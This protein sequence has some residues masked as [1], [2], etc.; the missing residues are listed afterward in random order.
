MVTTGVNMYAFMWEILHTRLVFCLLPFMLG[1]ACSSNAPAANEGGTTIGD[2]D[3]ERAG[4]NCFACHS[5]FK[6][7]GTV[8]DPSIEYVDIRDTNGIATRLYP[9][10]NRNFFRHHLLEPPFE[11]IMVG[12]DGRRRVMHDAPHG[13]CNACH[14]D[15]ANGAGAL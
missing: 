6:L 8:R 7:A 4:T 11:V 2:P 5:Q 15:L 3:R 10:G 12:V 13:S 14:H 1:T 9:N